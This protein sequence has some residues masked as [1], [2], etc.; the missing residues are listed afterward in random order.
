MGKR[1][2]S[3]LFFYLTGKSYLM[4][5]YCQLV[6]QDPLVFADMPSHLLAFC[7]AIGNAGEVRGLNPE[8]AEKLRR[9]S[10]CTPTEALE[11]LSNIVKT[12]PQALANAIGVP[13]LAYL[14]S[15]LLKFPLQRSL[16][17][18]PSKDLLETVKGAK[19]D[20]SVEM[21]MQEATRVASEIALGSSTALDERIF[22][23]RDANEEKTVDADGA[24]AVPSSAD[25]AV[26]PGLVAE[27]VPRAALSAASRFLFN[28]TGDFMDTCTSLITTPS[29]TLYRRIMA[30]EGVDAAFW[31][32]EMMKL[33]ED[34]NKIA[35]LQKDA[36][37][38]VFI[39]ELNT[40]GAIGWY[41]IC[42]IVT[43]FF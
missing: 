41:E 40:S 10:F 37:L 3:S 42:I 43:Y 4:A 9:V 6:N 38:V 16:L 33:C 30:H 18:G 14:D 25:A 21:L 29:T 1:Y 31:D 28:G 12:D 5:T 34:A 7:R 8:H 11:T 23:D 36:I 13:L 32:K 27:A 26:E 20:P 39:D 15:V 24:S 17:R 35:E 2:F 22:R 19:A